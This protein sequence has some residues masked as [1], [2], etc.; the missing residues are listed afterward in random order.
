MDG[1]EGSD[2]ERRKV[3]FEGGVRD[4]YVFDFDVIE[5]KLSLERMKKGKTPLIGLR[6]TPREIRAQ[7]SKR[8][9]R[10]ATAGA[11]IEQ[12]CLWRERRK[13]GEGKEGVREMAEG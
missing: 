11:D 3:F 6:E 1:A 5:A 9:R 13:G 12:S 8:Y 10:K 4:A 7:E 2:L